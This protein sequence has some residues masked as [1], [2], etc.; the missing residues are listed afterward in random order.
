M[1]DLPFL[2][3]IALAATIV[4]LSKS[5]AAV[6]LGGVNV[7]LLTM[8]MSA[9]DAAGVLLPV[10]VLIDMIALFVYAREVN[11]RIIALL[12]PGCLAGIGLGWAMSARV[13][14]AA[15][16]LM[17]GVVT[18]VF[19]VDSTVPI[20]RKLVNRPPSRPWGVFWGAVSGFT[21]FVSHTGG[22]PYQIFV[23]PRKLAPAVFAGTT[24][25]FF[26][27][28]NAIKLAPYAALGQLQP[29]NLMVSA[30]MVPLALAA[31]FGG[32]YIT[33][34]IAPVLFYRIAYG[35]MLVFSIKLIW[36]GLS[37]YLG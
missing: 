36:D 9:R 11:W 16:R 33:R 22:P 34:R 8:V 29:T 1:P 35:L 15:V 30:G 17:V 20:R 26:A 12:L 3:A 37:F 25:V 31:M 4:G 14:E 27:I 19:L 7:P 6:G 23:M 10:M 18:L 2:A 32:V 28:V 13:E 21:S 5:G 24:A